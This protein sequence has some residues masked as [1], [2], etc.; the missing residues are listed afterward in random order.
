M[1]F[2][3]VH[4]L[5]LVALLVLGL[6][7]SACASGAHVD[8]MVVGADSGLTASSK[9]PARKAIT[10][11]AVEGGSETHPLWKSNVSTENFNKALH[12]SLENNEF[13]AANKGRYKVNANLL[14]LEQPVLGGFNMTVT[15][16]VQYRVTKTTSDTPLFNE[17]VVTPY[18]ASFTSA[19]LGAE[20]L[21]LANEG[22]I[23]TNIRAFIT[24][25]KA[26]AGL[27]K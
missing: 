6:N 25:I 5:K 10:I 15:A 17:T 27:G 13:L 8:A 18:T 7:L 24:K 14:S 26:T 11:A 19:F 22:A 4:V 12:Q 21:R 16:H 2:K 20:R 3:N 1:R 23:K 9:S